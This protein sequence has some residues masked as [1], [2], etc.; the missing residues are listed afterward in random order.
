MK[1]IILAVALSL[2][3]C[4]KPAQKQEEPAPDSVVTPRIVR[5]APAVIRDGDW[6]VV[7]R[8]SVDAKLR[9]SEIGEFPA[10]AVAGPDSDCTGMLQSPFAASHHLWLKAHL[11]AAMGELVQD[12]FVPVFYFLSAK[13]AQDCAKGQDGM[14]V[15]VWAGCTETNGCNGWEEARAPP[16]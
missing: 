5:P 10:P 1:R 15:R 14:V 8:H 6:N 2:C 11:S 3:C 9:E 12:R 16:K 7:Q 13:A 4:G